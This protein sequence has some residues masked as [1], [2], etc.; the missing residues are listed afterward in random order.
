MNLP[1]HPISPSASPVTRALSAAASRAVNG[2]RAE[3]RRSGERGSA[4]LAALCFAAVLAVALS[5]YMTLCYRS[6]QMSSRNLNSGHSV[7]LAETGMEEALWALH[8]NDWT[9]WTITGKTATKTLSGFTYDNGATGSANLT[10]TNYDG[11][12]GTRTLSVTGVTQL[13]D[14]TS[15]RRTLSSNSA[16]APLFVNAIAATTSTVA[17][18]S[19]GTADSYDSSLGT[20][21]SQTPSYSAIV[22]SLAPATSSATVQLVNAQIKGYATSLYSGGPA[23]STSGRVYGP[24]TPATTKIDSSRISR[25][26]YQPVFNIQNVS[27]S[28]TV[29]YDP[30]VGTTTT[31]GSPTDTVPAI[32][33][34]SGLDLLDSTKIIVDGPVRL[35]VSGSLYIG[36][37]CDDP[38]TCPACLAGGLSSIEVTANGTLEIFVAGDI[39]IHGNGIN[40]LTLDPKRVA[41]YST[42]TLTTPDLKTTVPYYGVAYTPTGDF[43][44]AGDSTTVYGA[45][46]ARKVNLTGATPA[47]HYDLNLRNAVFA[48][49]DM[50]YAVANLREISP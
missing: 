14:G 23:Y 39:A 3:R 34:S 24:L 4:L 2:T 28:G 18:T 43:T 30:D 13:S 19:G 33:Y 12:T 49:V 7:E 46:V 37:C 10:I 25:N 27:G 16:Q 20:Y 5:S 35:V 45:I 9:D 50:P 6:L 48:G 42:N 17:F 29:L 31:I 26:P 22:A 21:A 8:N 40:N 11:T 15:I 41:I 38:T 44:V 47:I 32:Y 36:L 1:A